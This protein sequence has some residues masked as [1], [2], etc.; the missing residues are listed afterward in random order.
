MFGILSSSSSTVSSASV[1]CRLRPLLL[2]VGLPAEAAAAAAAAEA[3]AAAAEAP[4]RSA[5]EPRGL[6][7]TSRLMVCVVGG[8]ER[9]E[10]MNAYHGLAGNVSC[11]FF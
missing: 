11:L 9:I 10:M 8:G 3:E 6:E 5:A 1:V 7:G 2:A 4:P